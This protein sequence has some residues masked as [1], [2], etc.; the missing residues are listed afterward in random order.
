MLKIL[1]L[2]WSYQVL[3]KQY[4]D[5]PISNILEIHTERCAT[6]YIF[7][8]KNLKN[9][10]KNLKFIVLNFKLI[11]ILGLNNNSTIILEDAVET[12][13]FKTNHS[14]KF[15][16]ACAYSGSFA[17]GKG[18]EMIYALAKKSPEI[19]FQSMGTLMF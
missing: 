7:K 17:A 3:F 6:K 16:K 10:K 15:I 9:V 13:D 18:I 14:K 1:Y 11:N 5:V 19:E 4:L 12:N 8:L 2:A